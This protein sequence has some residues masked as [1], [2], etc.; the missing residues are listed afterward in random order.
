MFMLMMIGNRPGD[1]WNFVG[2]FESESQAREFF[3]QHVDDEV[4]MQIVPLESPARYC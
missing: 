2:P 4:E 1:K 3:T